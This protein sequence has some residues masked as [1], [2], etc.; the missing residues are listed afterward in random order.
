VG[1]GITE[2]CCHPASLI[3]IE[4]MYGNE[5]LIELETLC[6]EEVR[7]RVSDLNINLISFSGIGF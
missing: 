3:D 7:K 1:E 2:L 4:T 5:R 6:N